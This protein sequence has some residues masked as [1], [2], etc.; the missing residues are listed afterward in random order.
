MR[1]LSTYIK[2]PRTIRPLADKTRLSPLSPLSSST[3]ITYPGPATTMTITTRDSVPKYDAVFVPEV[4]NLSSCLLFWGN[5]TRWYIEQSAVDVLQRIPLWSAQIGGW[6]HLCSQQHP[7][8]LRRLHWLLLCYLWIIYSWGGIFYLCST[9]AKR[10]CNSPQ[11]KL[12]ERKKKEETVGAAVWHEQG[13][14]H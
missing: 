1:V 7:S 9:E 10:N 5:R 6:S 11:I 12:K 14:F 3:P 2:H 4:F 13:A 8:P